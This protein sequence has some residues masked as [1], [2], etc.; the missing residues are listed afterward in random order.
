LINR[1]TRY[2]IGF[3]RFAE[4]VAP[5]SGTITTIHAPHLADVFDNAQP[6]SLYVSIAQDKDGALDLLGE[7]TL[8]VN[9]DRDKH[10]RP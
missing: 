6:E 1:A 8:I 5:A 3:P 4:F 2:E 9:F 7:A 10:R